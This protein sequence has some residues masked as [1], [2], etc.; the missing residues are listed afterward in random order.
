MAAE[1]KKYDEQEKWLGK[2]ISVATKVGNVDLFN[3]GIAAF[4]SQNFTAAD[5]IFARYGREYPDQ[6]HGFYWQARSRTALDT[7]MQ[8]TLVADLYRK[9]IDMTVSD[10]TSNAIKSFKVNAYAY[11]A[12]YAANVEKDADVAIANFEKLLELDPANAQ[13]KKYIDLL[14]KGEANKEEQGSN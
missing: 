11:L 12:A 6:P 3:W 9:V 7:A 14:K 1:Q 8:D 2:Y 13:A 4:R 5:T 10:S